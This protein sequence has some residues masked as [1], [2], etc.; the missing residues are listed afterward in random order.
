MCMYKK[1]LFLSQIT[2]KNN[3]SK[4]VKKLLEDQQVHVYNKK[5]FQ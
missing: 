1:S 2:N 4:L 5:K 3:Y